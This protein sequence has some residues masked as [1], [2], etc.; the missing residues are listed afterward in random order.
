M[1][2]RFAARGKPIPEGSLRAVLRYKR[3]GTPYVSTFYDNFK[4]LE[5]W[6]RLIAQEAKL[7]AKESGWIPPVGPVE[8]RATFVFRRP[9][10]RLAELFAAVPRRDDLEK[11]VRSVSDALTAAGIW[12]DD[13]Q[14]AQQIVRKVYRNHDEGVMVSVRPLTNDD[15]MP[16]EEL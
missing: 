11:L 15:W 4:L 13:G 7:V 16:I 9:G 12:H 10:G 2:L 8:L 3:D 5:P 6:R 1:I 14:C